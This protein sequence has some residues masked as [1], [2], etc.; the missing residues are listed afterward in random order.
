MPQIVYI[1]V[2]AT[3][4]E[5]PS[6]LQQR[7]A[8]VSMGG[9]TLANNT[10]QLITSAADLT[11]IATAASGDVSNAVNSFYDQG[12]GSVYILELGAGNDIGSALGTYLTNN[13]N[14]FYAYLL[15][16]VA[17]TDANL[18]SL[19]KNY[20][21]LESMTYFF[22]NGTQ[23]GY[24]VF[25]G[26]KSVMYHTQSPNALA[27]ENLAAETFYEFINASPT[28]ARKLSPFAFR[29]LYG[30]TAWPEAGNA[31][32]FKTLKS[33]NVNIAGT[34]AV[35]GVSNVLL[36]WGYTMDGKPMSYWYAVDWAQINLAR[37]LSYEIIT[38]SQPG[39]NPLIYD[40]RGITR[41]QARAVNTLS[42]GGTFGVTVGS[43]VVNAIDFATYVSQNTGDYAT[44][45]YNG[46]S[47]TITPMRGFEQ[48]TF[49]LNVDFSGTA[50][51][52][53]TTG[54]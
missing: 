12:T 47:A 33:E 46:L 21:S 27:T 11:S 10:T 34:G 17:A 35:G 1:N 4:T 30:A 26:V 19:V 48:I 23:S 54:S 18:Q 9:T 43:A 6:D 2:S 38:G 15:P 51:V 37:D 41:L 20:V 3:A 45:T 39:G 31:T 44:G 42:R 29:Y 36:Y 32:L 50:I 25:S 49:Y 5:A 14:A 8:I 22:L 24:N 13:P 28:A 16:A 53:A 7:G 40:Q 52:N